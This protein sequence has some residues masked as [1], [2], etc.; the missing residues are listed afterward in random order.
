MTMV[1]D[2]RHRQH[3]RNALDN[4][5]LVSAAVLFVAIVSAALCLVGIAVRDTTPFV[6]TPSVVAG[7]LG[8]LNL[9]R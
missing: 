2:R 6:L 4:V 7:V 1:Q 9:R 5:N 8:I 3:E